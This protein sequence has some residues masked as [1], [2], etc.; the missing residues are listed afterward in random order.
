MQKFQ[1]LIRIKNKLQELSQ[2]KNR[3]KKRSKQYV[4]KSQAFIR[5]IE[6]QKS[7]K[8]KNLDIISKKAWQKIK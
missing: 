7:N 4:Q 5:F 2:Y 6:K 1:N 3:N 8:V